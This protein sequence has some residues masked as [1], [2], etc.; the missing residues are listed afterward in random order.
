MGRKI[1]QHK[2]L[3]RTYIVTGRNEAL[4]RQ[5]SCCR[6]CY[7]PIT[8]DTVTADHRVSRKQGGS[9]LKHNI[10]AVCKPCNQAKGC[11]TEGQFLKVIKNPPLGSHVSILLTFARRKIWIKTHKTCK[12]ISNVVGMVYDT[13]VGKICKSGNKKNAT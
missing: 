2:K 3:E 1:P 11:M 6:Y 4:E 10:D 8:S 9:N 5:C 7:E 13:P 12:N